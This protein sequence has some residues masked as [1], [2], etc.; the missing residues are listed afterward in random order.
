MVF[1]CRLVF[2]LGVMQVLVELG[3]NV[4]FLSV[5]INFMRIYLL[6]E[7]L[8]PEGLSDVQ[9]SQDPC[10]KLSV[11]RAVPLIPAVGLNVTTSPH[12]HISEGQ[13]IKL[14]HKAGRCKNIP[15]LVQA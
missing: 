1:Q 9:L 10:I 13:L 11:E 8:F 14:S 4:L 12:T 7:T 6:Q 5:K 15:Y 3:R 2:V